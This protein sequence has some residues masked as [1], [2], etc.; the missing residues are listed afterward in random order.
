MEITK[1]R[2]LRQAR[3]IVQVVSQIRNS[4]NMYIIQL[5]FI[6]TQLV[7]MMM[8][9]ILK[10]LFRK[11]MQHTRINVLCSAPVAQEAVVTS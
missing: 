3:K 5:L 10:C 1:R 8:V 7:V 2:Y 9:S 11:V 4:D 6:R